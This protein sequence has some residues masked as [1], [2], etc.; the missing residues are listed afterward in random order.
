MQILWQR[1]SLFCHVFQLKGG[2]FELPWLFFGLW[3]YEPSIHSFLSQ[4]QVPY[5]FC[6]SFSFLQRIVFP[7]LKVRGTWVGN[8]C[9]NEDDRNE[10]HWVE[11]ENWHFN[12]PLWY[13]NDL[14]LRA[15]CCFCKREPNVYW[16]FVEMPGWMKLF[17]IANL[18][19]WLSN[20]CDYVIAG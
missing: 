11:N 9:L 14:W 5:Q 2:F 13:L 1:F 16:G 4:L 10:G 3:G 15:L 17:R 8:W 20:S 18:F 6:F 19:L 12:C 7:Y